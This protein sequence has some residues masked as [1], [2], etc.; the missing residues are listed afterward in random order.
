MLRVKRPQRQLNG[1]LHDANGIATVSAPLLASVAQLVEQRILNPRVKGSSPFG[2]TKREGSVAP[3][4][5]ALC[6][7]GPFKLLQALPV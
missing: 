2:G 6:I 1:S 4:S 7:L 3:G 5:W